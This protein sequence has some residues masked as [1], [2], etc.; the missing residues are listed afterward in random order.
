MSALL[1]SYPSSYAATKEKTN[2]FIFSMDA[3]SATMTE[4][5]KNGQKIRVLVLKNLPEKTDYFLY[6]PV[7][8]GGCINTNNLI[9]GWQK[10]SR[11]NE[12]PLLVVIKIKDEMFPAGLIPLKPITNNSWAFG[13][14]EPNSEFFKKSG[15]TPKKLKNG[16]YSDLQIS[17]DLLP[18]DIKSWPRSICPLSMTNE[19]CEQLPLI[20]KSK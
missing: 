11:K 13:Y 6:P 7:K 4:E 3:K 12:L 1:A 16:S 9:L 15:L 5:I 2:P 10:W 14:L 20:T 18:I 8:Q 17:S 19:K